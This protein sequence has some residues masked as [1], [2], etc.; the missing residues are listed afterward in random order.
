MASGILDKRLV[1]VTGKGGVG[2][3]TVASAL[4]LAAARAGRR[5]ILCEVAQQERMSRMFR[6]EGVGWEEAELRPG[7]AAISI[8]P[9]LAMEEYLRVQVG[10]RALFHLLFDNRIFQYLAAAAPGARELVTMGKVW[11][12]AQLERPWSDDA[13]R[14][15]L[16]VVDAPATGHGLG[17]LRVPRTFSD[18]ARVGPIRRHADR[19]DAF[20]RDSR[21]TGIVTV[22]MPEE[23]PV[24]ETLEFRDRLDAEME[25]A[26]DL[27]VMNALREERFS[28]EEARALAERA[29]A[30]GGVADGTVGAA[31]AAAVAEHG[32]A[33]AEHAQLERLRAAVPDAVTLP[34]L[35][36]PEL[37]LE[38]VELLAESLGPAL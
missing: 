24:T 17:L 25:M 5:V 18:V 37:G 10:N 6:R 4:G 12:L 20:V 22:A 27:V 35:F 34:F 2:R 11:E 1:F 32:R 19:I 23:M 16:V 38:E 33:R 28:D 21:R 30:D 14:Y 13:T 26:I 31:M 3:S 7:L 36:E 29:A 15:D 9:Q 8:D